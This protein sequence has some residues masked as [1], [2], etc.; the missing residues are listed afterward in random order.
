MARTC[1]FGFAVAGHSSFAFAGGKQPLNCKKRVR[2]RTPVTS[3]ATRLVVI[4]L[5]ALPLP[6]EPGKANSS[7]K[8][9]DERVKVERNAGGDTA[10]IVYSSSFGFQEAMKESE[11]RGLPNP[12]A[13]VAVSGSEVYQSGYH[14]PD[15]FWEQSVRKQWDPKPT[16]WVVAKFFS[17]HLAERSAKED[18]EYE[19]T[20]RIKQGSSMSAIALRDAVAE[21]L[22]DMGVQGRVSLRGGSS[23]KSSIVILPAAASVSKAIQFCAE[24]LKISGEGSVFVFGGPMLVESCISSSSDTVGVVTEA[25]VSAAESNP[26]SLKLAVEN[27]RVLVSKEEGVSALLDGIVHFAML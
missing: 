8:E 1:G 26:G 20:L 22:K 18:E 17:D 3:R 12:D 11:S 21:K 27:D 25:A 2:H 5:D 24:M 6:P 16:R 10:Y 23:S 19:I 13:F 9:F 14:S 4:E 7:V 15:P